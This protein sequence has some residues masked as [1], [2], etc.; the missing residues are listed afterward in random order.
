MI[1]YLPLVLT[2]IGIIVAIVYYTLTLRNATKTRQVQLFMNIYETYRNTEFKKQFNSCIRLGPESYDDFMARFGPR[3]NPD[4]WADW[5][6]VASYFNGIGVLLKKGLIDVS[7]VEELLV[8]SVTIA[9]ARMGPIIVESR[10][11]VENFSYSGSHTDIG[12]YHGF[13]YLYN[14]LLRRNPLLAQPT[15]Q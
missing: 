7:L 3:T 14:E 9:W 13:E 2:G 4:V 12:F 5:Q 8:H 6:S 10:T 1:E 11:D 15:N